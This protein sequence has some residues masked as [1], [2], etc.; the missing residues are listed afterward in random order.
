MRFDRELRE[1][2]HVAALVQ[3]LPEVV[4]IGVRLLG[5]IVVGDCQPVSR[6][7]ER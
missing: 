3:L 5:R 6:P 7:A 2:R 1:P 4:V